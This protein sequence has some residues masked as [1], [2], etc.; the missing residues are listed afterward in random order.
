[1]NLY[2]V[3]QCENTGYDTYD[4]FVVAVETEKEARE[5]SPNNSY[6]WH[7]DK[8][9]FQYADGTETDE[10]YNHS[11]CDPKYVKTELIGIAKEG[12]EGI[13]CTSFN[14]G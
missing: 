10:I 12:V 4:S 8:W 11:W 9:F 3:S 13:V 6:K 5:T 7:D 14:A 2:L 1:M